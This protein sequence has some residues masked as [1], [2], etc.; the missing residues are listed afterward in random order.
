MRLRYEKVMASRVYKDPLKFINDKYLEVDR[1]TKSIENFGKLKLQKLKSDFTNVI[2]KL[3]T[4]SPLKTLVRGY[5]IAEKDGKVVSSSKELN[6]GDN[7][8][9]RFIDG[10]KDAIIK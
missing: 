8:T 5:S 2:A 9:L 1:F 4:L 7:L 6:S 10:N 3:D